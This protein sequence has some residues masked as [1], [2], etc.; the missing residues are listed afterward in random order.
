VIKSVIHSEVVFVCVVVIHSEV[1]FVC[2]VVVH[3]ELNLCDVKKSIIIK[4]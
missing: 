3:K 4:V 2:V 1:V